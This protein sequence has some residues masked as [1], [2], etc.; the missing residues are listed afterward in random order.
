[1]SEASSRRSFLAAISAAPVLPGFARKAKTVPPLLDH[2]LLG[3]SD[4]ERGVAFVEEQLGVRAAFGGVHPGRGT[5]NALLSLGTRH[6]LEII[7]PDP[8]QAGAKLPNGMRGLNEPRLVGWAAHPGDLDRFAVR[9]RGAGIAFE[10][11]QPGSRKTP[12]GRVLHWRT[13]T[14]ADD[15]GG[16]LPFFIEWGAVA[17]IRRRMPRTAR[18]WSSSASP[19]RIPHSLRRSAKRW[20]STYRSSRAKSHDFARGSPV[21]MASSR[22]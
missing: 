3:C 9:L 22:H 11:P 13:V 21:R 1:M 12:G 7:A 19:A 6:Y 16:V 5:Q 20:T 15:R 14:L 4:V 17:L 8:K 2:I 10:G 18:S